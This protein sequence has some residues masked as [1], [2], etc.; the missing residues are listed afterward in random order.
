MATYLATVT[1]GVFDVRTGTT[2][3]GIPYYI[4]TDPKV[5]QR[6]GPSCARCPAM[7]DYFVG[8]FGPYPFGST[9]AVVDHAPK[10]GYALETQTKPLYDSPPDELTV[11]HELAH[12][13][14]GDSVTL[15]AGGTSGSTR[16]S[17]SSAPG[18]GASTPAAEERAVL[19][20]PVLREEG[21]Q[22]G[23][24]PAAGRPRRPRRH[25]RR[26]RLRTRRDDPAG[27]AGQARRRH[28]LPDAAGVVRRRTRTAT[29]RWPSSPRSPRRTPVATCP[30]SSRPGC[31]TRGSRPP[32]SPGRVTIRSHYAERVKFA[33]P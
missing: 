8:L 20:Q 25:V 4:A 30:P 10:V 7:T 31:T 9:G 24:Q 23:V 3:G 22:L 28:L 1:T 5:T 14:F 16:V 11:S 2:P 15:S 17:R 29:S 33:H 6:A 32:G 12:M 26:L 27:A 13:W 19:L 18:C 21:R